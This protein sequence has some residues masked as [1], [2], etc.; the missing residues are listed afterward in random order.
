VRG[1]RRGGDIDIPRSL[2]P[3]HSPNGPL[4]CRFAD[5]TVSR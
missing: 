4:N 5:V 3:V 1:E 2:W